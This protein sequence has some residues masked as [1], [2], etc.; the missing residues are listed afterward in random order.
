V[1]PGLR[2]GEFAEGQIRATTEELL[3]ERHDVAELLGS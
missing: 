2:H 3:G 1:V